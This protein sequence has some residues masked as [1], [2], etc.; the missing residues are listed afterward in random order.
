MREIEP[1]GCNGTIYVIQQG[2]TMYK[3]AKK[4]R[5]NLETLMQNNPYLNVFNLK[6]GD[7]MCLPLKKVAP[8]ENVRPYVVK[9]QQSIS[10][11]LKDTN[12]TF[13]ELASKNKV[14]RDLTLPAGTILV[15]PEK[16]NQS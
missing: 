14:L 4:F 7:E 16:T 5:I 12:S 1:I 6:P 8:I 13:E 15:I 2:D 11:I 10:D 9:S 3:I